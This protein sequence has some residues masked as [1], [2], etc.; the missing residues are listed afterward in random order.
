MEKLYILLTRTESITSKTVRFFTN[1]RYTHASLA[2]DKEL[3]GL[4]S[5]GRKKGLKMFP[6][7]PCREGLDKGFFGRDP[8]TPCA[9]FEFEVTDEAYRAAK[10]EIDF[11]MTDNHLYKFS[12]LGTFA[13]K[14]G[15]EWT[16]KNKFFCSQFVSEILKRSGALEFP[17]PPSLMRPIDYP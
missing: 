11:Y 5:S 1:D 10:A 13:C 6:G 3:I 14:L 17:K 16:R 9:V 4:Y 2:F 15:I 7:G 8:H 12:I